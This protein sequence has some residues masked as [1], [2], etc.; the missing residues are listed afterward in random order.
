M[1][2]I[3]KNDCKKMEETQVYFIVCEL[4][5]RSSV[6]ARTALIVPKES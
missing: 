2:K 4:K 1:W 5:Q 6:T 3:D